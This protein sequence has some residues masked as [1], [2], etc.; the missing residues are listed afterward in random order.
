MVDVRSTSL[1]VSQQLPLDQFLYRARERAVGVPA[2]VL[3]LLHRRHKRS[4]VAS[5]VVGPK[6]HPELQCGTGKRFEREAVVEDV[7]DLQIPT[8][9]FLHWR[10]HGATLA[11]CCI[12]R[13]TAAA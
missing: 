5:V 6:V 7:V 10:L 12:G 3:Q 1:C 9:T 13:S 8:A 11:S 2:S 4:I